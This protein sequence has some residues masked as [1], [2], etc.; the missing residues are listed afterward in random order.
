MNSTPDRVERSRAGFWLLA[1]ALVAVLALL[2]YSVYGLRQRTPLR[3]GEPSPQTFVAPVATDVVDLL[4]T[5]RQRQAARAQIETVHT[6]D[7]EL[8]S[9][10]IASVAASGLPSESVA[11]VIDAY[12]DPTG[13][14]A[15]QIE[16]ITEEAVAVAPPERQREVRLVLERRLVAT[17]LP[18]ETLTQAARDAAAQAIR[19]VMQR[20]A[21]GEVIVQ[22]G[23]PLTEDHL[24]VLDRLG[25]YSASADAATQTVWI[26]IGC[27][28]L[29][30]LLTAP[31]VIGRSYVLA[32]VTGNQLA[33]LLATTA[34]VVGVQR[35]AVETSPYFL[36]A[37]L[38]PLLVAALL[39]TAPGLA[40]S[41][42]TALVVG[43]LVPAAPLQALIATFVGSVAASLLVQA[44]RT[45]ISVALAG[46]AGGGIAGVATYATVLVTGGMS[47]G[48]AAAAA[49]LVIVGGLLAGVV[50]L[51]LLPVAES[52]FGFLTDFRL[53][54]LSSPTNPLLQLL[55]TE[56]PGTYQHSLII[57]NLVEQA[58]KNIGGN[59]LLARV[60]ALF[61]DVGKTKRP[62]F[63]I[64]NQFSGENPHDHLSPHL[65]YLI[66][67]SHVRD[68]IELARQYGLP[69]ELEPFIA[70]HHG[71]TVLSYF[72]KRALEEGK[73]EEL[74]FRYPGPKPR[75]KET[76]VLM[77]A[78][79][80]ESAS[81]TL[82][83]PSPSAIR[84]L[85]DRIIEQRQQDGQFA[86][87]HLN[88]TDLEVIANT[89]E[90]MLTAV[91]HRRVSYPS[92]EEIRG[93]KVARGVAG[94]GA[95]ARDAPVPAKG[96]EEVSGGRRGDRRDR[97]LP[98]R[99]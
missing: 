52:V 81:R 24:R 16:R 41:A 47:T 17:A 28:A 83:D 40:W 37:P 79:S 88:F 96:G 89:F 66:V 62:Q 71:T 64:E 56:A 90:R 14:R 45:R 67:T 22:A 2:L 84:G 98:T 68:G 80:I 6:L 39:G 97:P 74:N 21:A 95:A 94:D 11:V 5:Q 76:A 9:L 27:V 58:V 51:G 36:F 86:E 13:V 55:V 8:R 33:F 50:A 19:P 18:D 54:E 30:L 46:L 57:S 10:V 15:D 99:S 1:T 25:L 77:L 12:Q 53:L 72:Y 26:V 4:A 3:L 42:W 59:A 48:E 23:E 43:L 35:L 70:E 38:A 93:L 61:H 78:D 63:F 49:G 82:Q 75:S 65:S 7:A 87:S 29:A 32:R 31:L 91:L 34:L 73:V 69:R 85:I 92:A 20:L 44:G 60:G